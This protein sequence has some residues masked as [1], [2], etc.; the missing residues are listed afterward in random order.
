MKY[1][2]VLLIFATVAGLVYW[3]LRPYLKIVRQMLGMVRDARGMNNGGPADLPR[4]QQ[5]TQSGGEKLVRCAACGTWLPSSRAVK[6]RASTN[7]YCSHACLERAA[8]APHAT[9]RSAS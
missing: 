9:R 8:D 2:F 1:L 6:L 3:R 4:R 7:S 5:S